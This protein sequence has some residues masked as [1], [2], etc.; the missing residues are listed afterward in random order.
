M[1]NVLQRDPICSCPQLNPGHV[2]SRMMKIAIMV[3]FFSSQRHMNNTP[4][5][6]G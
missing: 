2:R 5:E 1:S 4:G 3:S 6:S